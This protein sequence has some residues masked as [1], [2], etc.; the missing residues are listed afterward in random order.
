MFSSETGGELAQQ[1][2]GDS[3]AYGVHAN[4]KILADLIE[5]NSEIKDLPSAIR[6]YMQKNSLAY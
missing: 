3:H 2:L 1:H 5:E 6:D 4:Y